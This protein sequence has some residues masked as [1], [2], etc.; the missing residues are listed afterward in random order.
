MANEFAGSAIY[1]QWIYSGGTVQMNTDNR[2]WSYV[3]QS[4]WIDATAGADAYAND[5]A[6]IERGQV[7]ATFLLLSNM[8]TVTFAAFKRN[9]QGT[10]IWGEAGTASGAPKT[11]LPAYVMSA[12]RNVP[13]KDTVQMTVQFN[14]NGARVD[15]AY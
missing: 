15:G 8:G 2:D 5:L 3:D 4:D 9:T 10:L 1:A 11:T 12:T 6:S 14:Q 7:N 13:Y